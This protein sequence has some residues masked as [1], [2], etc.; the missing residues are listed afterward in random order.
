MIHDTAVVDPAADIDPSAEIGPW[1]LI[2]P[3]VRIGPGTR[4]GAHSVIEG[5]TTIGRDNHIAA[6]VTLGSIPQDKKY[7]PGEDT[8]LEIGDHNTIREYCSINRGTELG[9]SVTRIGHHNWIMAYCH[10]AHDCLIGDHNVLANST[11]LAGHVE[12]GSRATLGGYTGVHQFCR[13]GDYSFSSI[14]SI[15]V[16]DV[17]PFVIVDGNTARARGL[18]RVGLRR[19]GFTEAEMSELKRVYRTFFRVG[20]E[21]EEALHNI[22]QAFP[23][24]PHAQNFVHFVRGSSRGVVR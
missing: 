6:F 20:L 7:Q 12:I 2:G 9:G 8:R 24:H 23:N 18:N 14:A 15:I 4:V 21:L 3:D 16:K 13:L 19:N 5:P 10:I 1:C 22:E 11:N 17:P